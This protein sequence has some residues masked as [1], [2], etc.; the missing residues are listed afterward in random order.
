MQNSFG[1]R[2]PLVGAAGKVTSLVDAC[3]VQ[4]L[5]ED[6][7][8]VR[9][10][11][12]HPQGPDLEA[13]MPPVAIHHEAGKGVPFAVYPP[14]GRLSRKNSGAVGEG[15]VD[16]ALEEAAVHRL[17]RFARQEADRDGGS[18]IVGPAAK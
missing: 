17:L 18:R 10:E 15:L 11:P 6:R 1:V 3:R 13:E 4:A 9:P 2:Q 8:P 7:K 12:L 14:K 5:P 16:P